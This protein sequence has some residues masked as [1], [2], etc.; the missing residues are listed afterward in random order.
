[1]STT[2]TKWERV[3]WIHLAQDTDKWQVVVN[4]IMS[5]NAPNYARYFFTGCGTTSF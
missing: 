2:E 5:L 3:D 1:M 4:I